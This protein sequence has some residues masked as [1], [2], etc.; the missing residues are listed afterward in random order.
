MSKP[1][2]NPL[3]ALTTVFTHS[4]SESWLLTTTRAP[5]RYPAFPT[6]GPASCEPPSWND[7]IAFQGIGF[8]SPAICPSG[9]FVGPSCGVTKTRTQEGFPPVT[10][11]ETVAYCVPSDHTCTTDI[12]DFKGGVWGFATATA[13]GAQVTVAPAIQIRWRDSDLSILQTHPLTPGLLL[14]GDRTLPTSTS[15]PP[16]PSPTENTSMSFSTVVPVP[17]QT[18]TPPAASTSLQSTTS[19]QPTSVLP[20]GA[21]PQSTQ[22]GATSSQDTPTTSPS[23]DGVGGGSPFSTPNQKPSIQ[24][25]SKAAVVLGVTFTTLAVVVIAIFVLGRYWR[26]R[27]ERHH[28]ESGKDHLTPIGVGVWARCGQTAG[29]WGVMLRRKSERRV[30]EKQ[31]D[32]TEAG[33]GRGGGPIVEVIVEVD[34]TPPLGSRANPA[35]LDAA[36]KRN[37]QR[38]SW[39]SRISEVVGG[40]RSTR[41]PTSRPGTSSRSESRWTSSIFVGRTSADWEAFAKERW[42]NGLSV[43]PQAYRGEGN[44]YGSSNNNRHTRS[45]GMTRSV[46]RN[47]RNSRR[48]P[49][50]PSSSRLTQHTAVPEAKGHT[51]NK[52]SQFR[53]SE[54]SD[55]TFGEMPRSPGFGFLPSPLAR[56][57]R[58]NISAVDLHDGAVY[59]YLLIYMSPFISLSIF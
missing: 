15:P 31:R 54:R 3:A 11:G 7:N 50:P 42:P 22:P 27:Q 47:S 48:L 57:A 34:A 59:C 46:S 10:S 43:P 39:M 5:S 14:V 38:W 37:T 53:L 17:S 18:S 2:E 13:A 44:N 35:E 23:L 40:R 24:Q 36:D 33:M 19:P 4:C 26:K 1:L 58:E 55:G 49:S 52:S 41:S 20:I 12:T 6:G 16:A 21:S 32:D 28:P 9:F 29:S 30:Y 45:S 51:R 25:D 8:Y 56:S